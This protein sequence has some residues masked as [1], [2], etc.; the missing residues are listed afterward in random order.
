MKVV[1]IFYLHSR[2]IFISRDTL[3]YEHVF[4]YTSNAHINL[5]SNIEPNSQDYIHDYIPNFKHTQTLPHSPPTNTYFSH[6]TLL[7]TPHLS[8]ILG[9]I[10]PLHQTNLLH[11]PTLPHPLTFLP[12]N[13]HVLFILQHTFKTTISLSLQVILSSPLRPLKVILCANYKMLLIVI[14]YSIIMDLFIDTTCL[15]HFF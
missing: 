3:F 14:S 13:P 11:Q 4:P 9:I 8:P 12:K 7:L 2:T 5:I 10:H 15:T 6:T 1:I